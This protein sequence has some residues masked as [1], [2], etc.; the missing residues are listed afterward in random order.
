MRRPA[1]SCGTREL[2]AM[3]WTRQRS[4]PGISSQNTASLAL[5]DESRLPPSLFP[6]FDD[7]HPPAST[8]Q[9]VD[10]LDYPRHFIPSYT[11]SRGAIGSRRL[12]RAARIQEPFS[13]PFPSPSLQIPTSQP[14]S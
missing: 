3:P 4:Q 11:P 2:P 7:S 6:T 9:V 12:Q 5:P 1:L 14:A 13:P 10:L 8:T